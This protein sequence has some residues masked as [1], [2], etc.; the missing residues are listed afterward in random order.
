MTLFQVLTHQL[1]LHV[2]LLAIG[3][4]L[5]HLSTLGNVTLKGGSTA[6]QPFRAEVAGR[7]SYSQLVAIVVVV[8]LSFVI[9]FTVVVGGGW[10]SVDF[11]LQCFSCLAV[12]FPLII[13]PVNIIY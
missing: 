1:A 4:L 5:Q 6:V 2:D 3:A 13:V 11:V 12:I 9:H 10:S 7:L 8:G